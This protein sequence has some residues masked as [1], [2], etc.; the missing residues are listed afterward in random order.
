M[1]LNEPI[2]PSLREKNDSY[3]PNEMFQRLLSKLE[4]E[5]NLQDEHDRRQLEAFF[6][7]KN[8]S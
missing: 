2:A 3:V 5:A 8:R 7:L 1:H 6:K 4:Q